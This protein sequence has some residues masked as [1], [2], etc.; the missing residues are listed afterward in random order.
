[1]NFIIEAYTAENENFLKT[2]ID[3]QME[4]TDQEGAT[5]LPIQDAVGD[6]ATCSTSLTT[7]EK[8]IQNVLDV[9]PH[10]QRSFVQ[11]LLARY[12]S[13]E[14]AIAAVLE[15]NI[16]PDLD[17]TINETIEK[18]EQLK[19]G[20]I[21]NATKAMDAVNLG[22]DND[23]QLVSVYNKVQK[24]RSKAE[25]RFL[26]DKSHIRDLQKRYEEYGY[27]SED[28]DDEYDDSYEAMLENESKAMTNVLKKT[29]AINFV[30]DDVESESDTSEEEQEGAQQGEGRDTRKDFCENPELVR[31]R[32]AR[33]RQAKFGNRQP[34]K[35]G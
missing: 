34:P 7:E 22:A 17:E 24:V 21:E 18:E 8:E 1:M 9:L 27:I 33:N 30:A 3:Q 12:E 20:D 14:L 15:G 10:L 16:P 4:S 6:G 19:Q 31:E 2:F 11:K 29:G 13:T 25:K 32:W 35:S 26:D 28:Y 5:A 23:S